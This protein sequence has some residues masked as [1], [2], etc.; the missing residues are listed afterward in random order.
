MGEG[1]TIAFVFGLIFGSFLNVVI[2][3]F[4]DWASIVGQPSH[5]P[6]CKKPISWFDLIPVIS[7]MILRGRCRHCHKPIS[8]QYPIVELSTAAL[9][10]AGYFLVF[11][12]NLPLWQTIMAYIGYIGVIGT[13]MTIFFHD[14]YEMMIPDLFAYVFLIFALVFALAVGHSFLDSFYG[15]LVGFVPIA[16]LVY[17][18]RG[19]WMGEGDVKVAAGMGLLVGYPIA[20]TYLMLSFLLGGAFGAVALLGKFAKMKTQVP[21]APFLILGGLLALFFGQQLI[22]WYLGAIHYGYY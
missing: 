9:L 19:T 3:R 16:L 11:S 10:A 13:L 4:D 20:I 17:P 18:S 12:S 8:W 1:I 22:N 6:K 15:L 7:F 14:L 2:L 21:F 5:C